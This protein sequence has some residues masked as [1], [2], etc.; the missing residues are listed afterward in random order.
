[1]KPLSWKGRLAY[2]VAEAGGESEVGA[3]LDVVLDEEDGVKLGEVDLGIAGRRRSTG[4]GF[5]RVG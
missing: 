2:E 4:W 5:R 1:M 3:E